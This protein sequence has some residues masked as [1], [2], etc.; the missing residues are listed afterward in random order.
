MVR[1]AGVLA[2]RLLKLA[3]RRA[4]EERRELLYHQMTPGK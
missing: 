4:R 2:P 1:A 3:Q